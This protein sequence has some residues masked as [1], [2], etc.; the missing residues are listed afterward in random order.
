MRAWLR[1]LR[2]ACL[3]LTRVPVAGGPYSDEEWRW[4]SG[5]FPTVGILIAIPMALIFEA[6]FPLGALF[7]AVAAVSATMLLTGGFHED[8]LA[9]TADAMGGSF[10]RDRLFVILKDSRLGAFGGMALFAVLLAKVAL[11]GRV[12]EVLAVFIL[13]QSLSRMFP[14]WLMVRLPYVTSDEASKSRR[15]TRAGLPQGVL[16]TIVPLGVSLACYLMGNVDLLPLGFAWLAG[17]LLM[18]ICAWRFVVRAGGITGDFLGATQ[19]VTELGILA[20]LV[21]P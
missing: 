4:S 3:F 18:L 21:W 8:G 20:A 11:L 12:Q 5:W 15:V 7:A 17:F 9:D 13:S 2:A 19:Q 1:G 16:A 14:I 10:D 6:L